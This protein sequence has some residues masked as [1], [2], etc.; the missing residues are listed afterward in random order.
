MWGLIVT[1]RSAW[2]D[3]KISGAEGTV[4]ALGGSMSPSRA[5][6]KA[7]IDAVE[8]PSYRRTRR[9]ASTNPFAHPAREVRPGSPRGARSHLGAINSMIERAKRCARGSRGGK[10]D[11]A[12]PTRQLARST[13]ASGRASSSSPRGRRPERDVLHPQISGEHAARACC[14]PTRAR[15]PPNMK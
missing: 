2:A 12:T 8:R 10:F 1:A 7:A 15:V 14:G 5:R 6:P 4:R 3:S 13:G 11:D 9:S